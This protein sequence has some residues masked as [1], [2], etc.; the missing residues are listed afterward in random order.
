MIGHISNNLPGD[1]QPIN[2]RDHG[3]VIR[4]IILKLP[5]IVT[6]LKIGF[7]TT[8]LKLIY[9]YMLSLEC[10]ITHLNGHGQD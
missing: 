7:K 2:G 9:W 4:C 1:I 3:H 6:Y 8:L 5:N 10:Q